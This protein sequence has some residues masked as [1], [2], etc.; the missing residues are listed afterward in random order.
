MS[1]TDASHEKQHS[2]RVKIGP[3][4]ALTTNE[5]LRFKGRGVLE[6]SADGLTLTKKG[7][8][9]T[10]GPS[11]SLRWDEL[12]ELKD[13][14]ATKKRLRANFGGS[15]EHDLVMELR[16][17]SGD[18]EALQRRLHT[19]PDIVRA[20][21]CPACGGPV[22]EG[23]CAECGERPRDVQRSRGKGLLVLGVGLAPLALLLVLVDNS[24]LNH[25]G[26][27]LAVPSLVLVLMGLLK[28][29][30]GVRS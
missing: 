4:S 1:I 7:A 3:P 5:V 24:L 19:S 2:Y 28:T 6:T 20:L 8:F 16:I 22:L 26:L 12:R 30:F 9:G 27:G 11:L 18:Q 10:S 29:A 21:R 23:A 14:I 17:M 15:G 13:E 25:A